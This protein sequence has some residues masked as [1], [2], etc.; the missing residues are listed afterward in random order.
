MN[1]K[2]I[3]VFVENRPGRL[4]EITRFLGDNQV[5]IR[6]LSIADTKDFGILRL[7]VDEPDKTVQLLK[8]NGYMVSITHVIAVA[9]TDEPGSLANVME[10]LYKNAISVEYMYAFIT[11]NKENAYVIVRVGDN[12]KA[13]DILLK[14]GIQLAKP[15][16]VYAL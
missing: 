13:V 9:M 11:R 7:I 8:D 3:S 2:Q 1:I 12:L 5:D 6:A 4:A 10:I 14:N 16:D 15:E